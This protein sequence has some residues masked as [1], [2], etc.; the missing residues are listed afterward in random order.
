ML[1]FV[2]T[3]VGNLKD[4]TLRALEVLKSVDLIA[5]EDT[6]TSLKLLNHYEIKKP[7]V[8]YHKFNEKV[9]GEKL[10]GELKSGKNIAL[11]TDAGTPVISDPG[12]VLCKMLIESGVEYT[13]IPG[14]TA[15]V[16][17]LI[18]S[19]LD[20]SRFCFI[21]FLPEKKKDVE[22]ILSKYKNF[23][24]TLIFYCAPHDVIKTVENLRLHLGDRQAVAVKEITK[25]HERAIRFN[26]SDGYPEENPK[27]EFVILV[28]RATEEENPNL[29]LTVKEHIKLYTD[30]GMSNMDAV[31][32]VAKERKMPKSEVYKYS[33]E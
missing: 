15:F 20:A 1:Y 32:L 5:C 12:N 23:D 21:G 11:I 4:I 13:V 9:A 2:S 31:K 3:P 22:Q 28:E 6:R 19:G 18:L 33:I 10:I 14:A 8:S 26:L 24:A 30:K 27:G 25:L 29:S 17:A 16:P 7:L